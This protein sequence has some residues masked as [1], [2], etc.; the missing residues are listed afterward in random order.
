MIDRG[1]QMTPV[2]GVPSGE[3]EAT[4]S[5][6]HVR[7]YVA[8]AVAHF[9]RNDPQTAPA[10]RRDQTLSSTSAVSGQLGYGFCHT[11]FISSADDRPCDLTVARSGDPQ[12]TM[13]GTPVTQR[14]LGA[15]HRRLVGWRS[16]Q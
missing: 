15:T 2:D 1:R 12:T 8:V 3:G 5:L 13:T 11:H 16:Y 10:K 9:P 7:S 6:S 14:G 4:P